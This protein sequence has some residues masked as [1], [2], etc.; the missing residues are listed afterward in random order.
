MDHSKN[1]IV[2]LEKKTNVEGG[3]LEGRI[4]LILDM[5][6]S[7]Y[8]LNIQMEPSNNCLDIPIKRSREKSSWTYKFGSHWV[9]HGGGHK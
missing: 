2:I 1:G 6:S 3:D 7:T 9:W 8:L 5:V 4:N